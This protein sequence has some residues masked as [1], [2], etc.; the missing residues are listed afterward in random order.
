[1]EPLLLISPSQI[2]AGVT[3]RAAAMCCSP[4]AALGQGEAPKETQHWLEAK[5]RAMVHRR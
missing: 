3:G 5:T 1:L 4:S 2:L